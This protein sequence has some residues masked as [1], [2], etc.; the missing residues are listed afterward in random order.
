MSYY[1]DHDAREY[2]RYIQ[3][4]NYAREQRNQDM[5]LQTKAE[6]EFKK[7]VKAYNHGKNGYSVN[8]KN[9]DVIY[10]IEKL[11]EEYGI[12]DDKSFKL[13]YPALQEEFRYRNS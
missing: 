3:Q 8:T 11:S 9:K 12:H 10:Y 7:I 4:Q 6:K 13:C 1:I 5:Q 2:A